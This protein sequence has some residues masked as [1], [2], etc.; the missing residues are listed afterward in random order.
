[1]IG[2]HGAVFDEGQRQNIFKNTPVEVIGRGWGELGLGGALLQLYHKPQNSLAVFTEHVG[3]Y[4]KLDGF[5]AGLDTGIK[6]DFTLDDFRVISLIFDPRMHLEKYRKVELITSNY[7]PRGCV[8]CS[9]TLFLRPQPVL[10]LYPEDVV[11]CIRKAKKFNKTIR[12]VEFCDNHF[13]VGYISRQ[14]VRRSGKQWIKKFFHLTKKGRLGRSDYHIE[15]TADAADKET[16]D[17]LK[18]MGTIVIQFGIESFSDSVLTGLRKGATE[19]KNIRAIEESIRLGITNAASLIL[20]SPWETLDTLWHTV[21]VASQLILKEIGSPLLFGTN[22]GIYLARCSVLAGMKNLEFRNKRINI[23]NYKEAFR[24]YVLPIEAKTK[25]LFINTVIEDDDRTRKIKEQNNNENAEK[26][27]MYLNIHDLNFRLLLKGQKDVFGQ[28]VRQLLIE[29]YSFSSL[30]K[31]YNIYRLANKLI[32]FNKEP[33]T[34]SDR[35]YFLEKQQVLEK[36]MYR[37]LFEGPFINAVLES[38][39]NLKKLR[40]KL[41]LTI[42]LSLFCNLPKVDID[43]FLVNFRRLR[44]RGFSGVRDVISRHIKAAE[45]Y[46]MRADLEMIY[47]LNRA[48]EYYG[49]IKRTDVA[50]KLSRIKATMLTKQLTADIKR[51]FLPVP[52]LENLGPVYKQFINQT[53][54][55]RL[56]VL[57]GDVSL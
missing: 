6:T 11:F 28:G 51:G 24:E 53:D 41:K 55:L 2:G 31:F 4:V 43:E 54:A 46:Q 57:Q 9:C 48:A 29:R 56:K 36:R 33:F 20:F 30:I 13:G 49:G 18:K 21:D 5:P 23:S 1:M 3:F 50:E 52:V 10:R 27:M 19:Q 40:R 17:V 16:M 42:Y 25:E 14:G 38:P 34:E 35:L 15:L 45:L 8:F 12:L 47:F 32:D 26:F 37:Y 22:L 7:C 39:N 44:S